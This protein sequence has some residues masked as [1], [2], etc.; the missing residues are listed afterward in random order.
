MNIVKSLVLHFLLSILLVY[1]AHQCH[2]FCLAPAR[3]AASI[4]LATKRQHHHH[5]QMLALPARGFDGKYGNAT[6][7]SIPDPDEIAAALGIRPYTRAPAWIWKIAWRGHGRILPVLHAND[8]ARPRDSDQSL[9]VLWNKAIV[10]LTK[11]SPAYDE[12]WTYDLLPAPSRSL[13]RLVRPLFP[14]LHHANIELRTTYLDSIIQQE[15]IMAQDQGKQVRL[16]CLGGGYDARGARL[17]STRANGVEQ[18]WELD[19]PDVVH[20]K[21]QMLARLE[22][23][24]NRRNHKRG[25][26]EEI[27]CYPHLIHVNLNNHT[28]ATQLLQ[29]KILA[30]NNDSEATPWHTI[31]VSEGVLIY[32]DD[33]NGLLQTCAAAVVATDDTA[34]LCFADRLA[35]VP[36][37]NE[38]AGRA[39]LEAAGWD[40]VEWRPKPGLARHMGLARLLL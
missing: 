4:S 38:T 24:R 23:R 30:H 8:D 36:G 37:G 40:L 14:R 39:A 27:F 34:S 21:R 12:E 7:S 13:L 20:A 31:F 3:T 6:T 2:G 15:I 33:P 17:L 25:N 16:V 26:Q 32:L 19:L 10:S 35:N 9:K 18:A 1:K 22:R 5:Q 29:D 11:S 28:A